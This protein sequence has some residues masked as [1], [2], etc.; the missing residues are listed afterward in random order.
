M[1]LLGL[2]A[3]GPFF[4]SHAGLPPIHS[5]GYGSFLYLPD[6]SVQE[7]LSMRTEVAEWRELWNPNIGIT[8]D[9]R[10][11]RYFNRF[12]QARTC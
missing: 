5:D 7:T 3:L 11:G 8:R 10:T 1:G 4:G 6:I 2:L 9:R 12:P